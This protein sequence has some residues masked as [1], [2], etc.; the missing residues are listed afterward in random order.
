MRGLSVSSLLLTAAALVQ[1]K[2]VEYT[3]DLAHG[4]VA[5]DGFKRS[6]V[7]INGITPGPVLKANKGDDFMVYVNN[8][9]SDHSM[10]LSTTIHWHGIVSS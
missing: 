9:L 2:T 4:P 10:R 1:S 5:P 8:G 6:A 3:F 7:T